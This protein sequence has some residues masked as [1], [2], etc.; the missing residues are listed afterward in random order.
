MLIYRL[1]GEL[2][3]NKIDYAIVGGYAVTLHGAVRGTVDL[4]LIIN[5]SEAD[6]LRIEEVLVSLGLESKLPV[7][8]KQV[9]QFREEYIKNKNLIAW[10][11]YNPRKPIEVVDIIITKN[12]KDIR[13]KKIQSDGHTLKIIS[14]D[15][16]IQMKSGTGR[17]QD[18]ADGQALQKLKANSP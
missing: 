2:D 11:F 4:D 18:E 7:T 17:A 9:F 10:S 8:G 12:L 15:D 14:L 3:R 13:I 6:F 5:F 1:T 16:L